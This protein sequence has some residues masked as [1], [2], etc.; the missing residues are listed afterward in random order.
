MKRKFEHECFTFGTTVVH[1]VDGVDFLINTH[2]SKAQQNNCNSSSRIILSIVYLKYLSEHAGLNHF[3]SDTLFL[4]LIL[5]FL[6][7]GS[8]ARSELPLA[9]PHYLVETLWGLFDVLAHHVH[10]VIDVFILLLSSNEI[11]RMRCWLVLVLFKIVPKVN[12]HKEDVQLMLGRVL[13]ITW[14]DR[15]IIG[16]VQAVDWLIRTQLAVEGFLGWSSLR[17]KTEWSGLRSNRIAWVILN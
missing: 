15:S 16:G 7:C 13:I 4:S 9:K 14:K 2:K 12:C 5:G 1:I 17:R 8:A 3:S 11:K 6:G 10:P